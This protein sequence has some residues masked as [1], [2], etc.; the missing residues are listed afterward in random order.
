L[1]GDHRPAGCAPFPSPRYGARVGQSSSAR[2]TAHVHPGPP[3][4]L[5]NPV[6]AAAIGLVLLGER[7][8]GGLLGLIPA[9]IGAA[10]AVRGVLLLSRAQART[11]AEAVP[12]PAVTR[13]QSRVVI[14]GP[15]L[16]AP[17]AGEPL[18][19]RPEPVGTAGGPG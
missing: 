15:A 3:P 1:L 7:L 13:P 16:A 12:A 19:L 14:T 10:A 8:Q 17:R 5:A 18:S 4:T 9:L 11:T 2:A 6:A